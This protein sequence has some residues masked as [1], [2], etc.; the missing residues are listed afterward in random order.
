MQYAECQNYP[1]KKGKTIH[2]FEKETWE[3][4]LAVGEMNVNE[5]TSKS[6]LSHSIHKHNSEVQG[7]ISGDY[8]ERWANATD[9]L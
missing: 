6:R 1:Q 4:N 7:N 9:G 3:F 5:Q 8:E 2:L